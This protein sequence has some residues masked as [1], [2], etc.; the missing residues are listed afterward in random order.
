MVA[1]WRNVVGIAAPP[2][3]SQELPLLLLT[4]GGKLL[5]TNRV[6]VQIAR[7]FA[8]V[9]VCVYEKGLIPPLVEMTGLMVS[10]VEIG[11][12]GDVEV[13]HEFLQIC[14]RRRDDKMEMVAHEDKGDEADLIDLK[15]PG[16]ELKEFPSVGI[17]PKDVLPSVPS[18]GDVVAGVLV[19][20]A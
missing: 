13:A 2:I 1:R 11:G 19:L 18:A 20:N 16:K 9:A 8:K 10:L 4:I 5:R 15:R 12:V 17:T 14:L 6:Q 3:T 7:D